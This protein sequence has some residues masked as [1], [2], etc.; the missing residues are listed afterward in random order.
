MRNASMIVPESP[1]ITLREISARVRK[2]V[3]GMMIASRQRRNLL[4]SWLAKV[5]SINMSLIARIQ[6]IMNDIRANH[7]VSPGTQS[8]KFTELKT[9]TYQNI[10][11]I[12]GM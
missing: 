12:S 9:S 7:P 4:F 8:E 11:T 10:V 1:M 3:I 2:K 6:S 5:S